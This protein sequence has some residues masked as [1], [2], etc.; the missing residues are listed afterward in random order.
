ML[1]YINLTDV[2]KHCYLPSWQPTDRDQETV[3]V[4][5]VPS[6]GGPDLATPKHVQTQC[7]SWQ[8]KQT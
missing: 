2:K 8:L 6:V 5:Q 4:T 1:V 7:T 3:L